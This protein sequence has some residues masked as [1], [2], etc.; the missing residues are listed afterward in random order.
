MFGDFIRRLTGETDTTPSDVNPQV[1]F[2]ALLVRVARADGDYADSEKAMIRGITQRWIGGSPFEAAEMVRQAEE[3]EAGAADTVRFT[4]AIKDAVAYEARRGVIKDI[5][6]VVLADGRR[7]K[8]EDALMRL[9]ANL[10]GVN[11]RD[12]NLARKSVEDGR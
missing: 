1:A 4:R 12:S 9:I 5:W 3:L 6:R 2:P 7:D 10:L 8:E 11:D